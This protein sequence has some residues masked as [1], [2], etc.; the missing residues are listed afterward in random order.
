ME[1]YRALTAPPAAPPEL[2]FACIAADGRVKALAR[3]NAL[4]LL[5][6]GGEAFSYT[7]PPPP[8]ADALR[9]GDAPAPP[10]RR[11]AARQLSEFALS[12]AAPLLA[13][14][15][16]LRN[17]HADRPA[18]APPLL[19]ASAAGGDA[20]ALGYRVSH[21][22]WPPSA[23]AA[24]EGGHAEFLDG[25]RVALR[26][27]CGAARLVLDGG[28][29]GG[30]GG[31]RFAVCYPLLLPRPLPGAP[32]GGGGGGAHTHVWQTQVFSARHFPPR[33]APALAVA[34]AVAAAGVSAGGGGGEGGGG[35]GLL[36]A[37][38]GAAA[39]WRPRG[40]E[41][42]PAPLPAGGGLGD[43]EEN[44]EEQEAERARWAAAAAAAEGD[45]HLPPAEALT[46]LPEAIWPDYSAAA[47]GGCGAAAGAGAA[48]AGRQA[49][50]GGGAAAALAECYGSFP[51]G[52]WWHEAAPLLPGEPPME[53]VW[54][55]EATY[56]FLQAAGE[57]EAWLHEDDSVMST[58]GAD[59]VSHALPGEADARVYAAGALPESVTSMATGRR[60]A[61]GAVAARALKAAMAA[62]AQRARALTAAGGA[63]APSAAPAPAWRRRPGVA[64]APSDL[65]DLGPEAPPISNEIL[66][67]QRVEGVGS[68]RAYADG[69]VRVLFEDR[70][71]LNLG[72][73]HAQIRLVLPDG[74][75]AAVSAA[76]PVGAEGYARTAA[77]FAAWAFRT[78]AER[79]A[80]LRAQAL[81]Q[82]EL[83]TTARMA[84]ICEYGSGARLPAA[85][86]SAAAAAADAPRHLPRSPP[87]TGAGRGARAEAGGGGACR[88]S[89]GGSS[90]D[91]DQ[92]APWRRGAADSNDG[93]GW[94]GGGGG[95]GGG[96]SDD[97][98]WEGAL[99]GGGYGGA[100][101]AAAAA[102]GAEGHSRL[103]I[104]PAPQE[105]RRGGSVAGD[106]PPAAPAAGGGGGGGGGAWGSAAA[107]AVERERAVSEML[108]RNAALAQRL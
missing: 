38:A 41:A 107:A 33:W 28:G 88:A 98:P 77:E 65:P 55:P 18:L 31:G 84:A 8:A 15:L 91:W 79:G 32:G 12:G 80:A 34:A 25:G 13:E 5:S 37:A 92:G 19:R 57:V 95:S 75:A 81:V 48:A 63:T 102:G 85:A 101:A 66:E 23:A 7:P 97:E 99:G 47:G 54:T 89:G 43:D 72:P 108:A 39:G 105:Q 44:E 4:L 56:V 10:R 104:W 53:V 11:A 52:S 83:R 100:A 20:F 86:A 61:V 14:A 103:V 24:L 6:S 49:G 87:G 73:D 16:R 51:D 17:L 3:D 96:G 22:Y 94:C 46:Q 82:A 78:P 27:R 90:W 59:F 36:I 93:G 26:S 69:R 21:V 50:G 58:Q 76:N 64:A 45:V 71:I 70:T 67:D 30:G 1:P 29:G 60:L 35:E 9:A 42:P 62:A 74:S 40:G 106:G 68:F 2:Q